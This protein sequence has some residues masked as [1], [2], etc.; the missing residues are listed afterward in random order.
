M[1]TYAFFQG[2]IG[3]QLALPIIMV[4]S[5]TMSAPAIVQGIGDNLCSF[6]TNIS[7]SKAKGIYK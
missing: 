1:S 4:S 7:L 5:I 6:F 3:I 2:I